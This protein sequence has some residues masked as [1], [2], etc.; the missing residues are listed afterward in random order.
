MAN[1][2]VS[3]TLHGMSSLAQIEEEVAVYL[4]GLEPGGLWRVAYETNAETL[5][6]GQVKTWSCQVDA[7][8][9]GG[10]RAGLE[11]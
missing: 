9:Q 2:H 8:L 7:T 3:F 10:T 6:G 11:G 1:H 5:A 4:D